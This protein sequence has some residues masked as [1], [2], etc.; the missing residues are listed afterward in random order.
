M[1]PSDSSESSDSSTLPARTKIFA[2]FYQGASP[3][4]LI[5]GTM[6]AQREP[7][8]DTRSRESNR[9]VVQSIRGRNYYLHLWSRELLA[10]IR[11]RW[12]I[13][14]AC[15]RGGCEGRQQRAC[16]IR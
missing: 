3:P 1:Y 5:L 8:F 4:V 16:V 6:W 15:S 11:S 7:S 10:M 13:R 14:L 2:P 9:L 12:M